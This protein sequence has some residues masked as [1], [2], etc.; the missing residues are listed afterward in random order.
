MKMCNVDFIFFS[1]LMSIMS[2]PPA[3]VEHLLMAIQGWFYKVQASQC[4]VNLSYIGP[5]PIMKS[6][7]RDLCRGPLP[8][9]VKS[10][11]CMSKVKN[12]YRVF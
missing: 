3:G 10:G 8:W 9:L 4:D 1:A 2:G 12:D 11:K 5:T 6:T 7:R